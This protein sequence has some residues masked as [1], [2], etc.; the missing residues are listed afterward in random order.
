MAGQYDIVVKIG[1]AEVANILAGDNS[2][3]GFLV[4]P[5]RIEPTNCIIPEEYSQGLIGGIQQGIAQFSLMVRDQYGNQINPLAFAGAS[6]LATCPSSARAVLLAA[7]YKYASALSP[8]V[9]LLQML[10]VCC[11][12]HRCDE[13]C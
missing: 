8:S 13:T 4:V 12:C 10:M 6:A 1:G 9:C 7:L 5:G 11:T 2:P 3:D